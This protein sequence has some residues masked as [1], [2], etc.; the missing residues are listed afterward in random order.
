LTQRGF[1]ILARSEKKEKVFQWRREDT[2]M[3]PLQLKLPAWW[4]K[5]PEGGGGSMPVGLR[6]G[7][8]ERERGAPGPEKRVHFCLQRGKGPSLTAKRKRGGG[9]CSSKKRGP[10]NL[11]EGRKGVRI[12]S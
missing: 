7:K 5:L 4:E 9:H 8:G 10:R 12:I 11:K 3:A 2:D 6:G 1:W